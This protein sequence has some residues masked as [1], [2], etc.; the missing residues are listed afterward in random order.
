MT[1]LNIEAVAKA[2]GV[3]RST[4]SRAFS[5]PEAVNTQTRERILSVAAELGYTMSPFAKA[6]RSKTSVFIPLIVPNLTNPFYA[7]LA[8]TM[9]QAA[10]ERGYQLILCI[11][12]R[13]TERTA[14]YLSA[15]QAL[16]APF[17]V[18][19]PSTPVDLD[20]LE[21]FGLGERVVV[22]DRVDDQSTV[23][24][25]TVDN[26]RGIE[27][28]LAHLRSL[29][30]RRIGYVSGISGVH[31]AHQRLSAY[32]VQIHHEPIVL[33]GGTD[34]EAGTRAA[35]QFLSMND[36]P[37]AIIAA[38]DMTA[39]GLISALNAQGVQV[40]TD[41]SVIGFDGLILGARYN[42]ALTTVRQ[43]IGEMGH[44]AI[45]LAEEKAA[46]GSVNHVLLTPEL[47][48]RASTAEPPVR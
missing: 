13:E 27:L 35:A 8:T 26:P 7:E 3:H 17:G 19:A 4:V 47:L 2:A 32:E 22:I 11:T 1:D 12:N 37:T 6:L 23:P 5:R 18:V 14:G 30:H 42:P 38:N 43:P 48:V 36:R 20:L 40:P 15:L 34:A 41:V 45:D 9:T 29:G 31:T 16:Y 33:D 28:A 21:Q 24:S 46:N 10:G 44:I 39:F 25:V